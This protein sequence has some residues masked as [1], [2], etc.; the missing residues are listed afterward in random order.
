MRRSEKAGSRKSAIA[1]LLS[2]SFLMALGPLRRDLLPNLTAAHG[3][4]ENANQAVVLS[5]VAV[6]TSVFAG[7]RRIRWPRGTNLLECGLIGLGL[8]VAPS[9]ARAMPE[10]VPAL[11]AVALLALAT[12]FAAVLE[13]YLRRFEAQPSGR[14]LPAMACVGGMFLIFPIATPRT[15]AAAEAWIVT[16]VAAACLAATNCAGVALL[17]KSVNEKAPTLAVAPALA[18]AAGTGAMAFVLLAIFRG[19]ALQ[20]PLEWSDIGV[21]LVWPV[22]VDLP[23]I[24]LLF[25]LMQRMAAAQMTLRFVMWPLMAVVIEALVLAQRLTLQTW[26][27]LALVTAGSWWALRNRVPSVDSQGLFSTDEP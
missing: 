15:F 27:G 24:F 4:S 11:T 10:P 5:L 23:A 3:L 17:R 2:L 9:L 22:I 18:V 19:N 13:P 20:R 12:V 7:L 8:F 16:I 21:S 26:T 14:I 6:T 1:G 25:W